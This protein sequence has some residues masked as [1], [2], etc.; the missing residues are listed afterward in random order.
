[1]N[2]NYKY[3]HVII[4]AFYIM[5]S[6]GLFSCKKSFLNT[7]PTGQVIKQE[8]IINL[9]SCEQLLTG[10]YSKL[11]TSFYS[12]DKNGLLYAD[13][14]ADNVKPVV[15]GS[16]L[17]N[18]YAWKQIASADLSQPNMNA[19][20]LSGYDI[21]RQASL[22]IENVDRFKMED[23]DKAA[24]LNGQALA[25]RAFIHFQLLNIFAQPYQFTA[26]GNHPGIPYVKTSDISVTITSRPTVAE[27][28]TDIIN[29]LKNSLDLISPN[30]TSTLLFNKNAVEGLLA[31]IYLSGADYANAK[32]RAL[33]VIS[34]VP[35]MTTDYP[36]KLFTA[37]DAEAI[38]QL[39]PLYPGVNG[40]QTSSFTGYYYRKN[41]PAF[42]ASQDIV[43]LLQEYP[44]DVRN[45]WITPKD[46]DWVITKYPSNVIP[47][48]SNI[49]RSY[50]QTLIRASEMYLIAAECYNMEED[51]TNAQLYLN[52]VRERAIPGIT[53]VTSTGSDLM[54]DIAKE[55][56]KE[57]CFEGFRLYDLL[58]TGQSVNR[59]DNEFPSL[60]YPNPRAISPLPL[61]D[62]QV[63]GLTQNPSY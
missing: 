54:N 21:I 46:P 53:P 16:L 48:F 35:L 47:G 45:T 58:R 17:I 38:F 37:E 4:G 36:G 23:T 6:V 51:D 11:S 15:G 55:R 52:A 5:M 61:S 2:R 57:L 7:P 13:L 39:L 60:P 20:W 28:Y 34:A 32:S 59:L 42:L 18:H 30:T 50:Y 49:Y 62:I 26:Q 22:I 14:A 41:S 9:S 63:N 19:V 27:N 40:D 12:S 33:H 56:R 31:R 1:M 8:Y 3:I 10:V 25:V 43:N 24:D 29:D 44:D